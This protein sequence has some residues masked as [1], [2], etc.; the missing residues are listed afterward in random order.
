MSA[1]FKFDVQA[2][3]TH[4]LDKDLERFGHFRSRNALAL[5]DRLVGLDTTGGIVG[6][7]REDLLQD[8]GCAIRIERPNLHL[9]EALAAELGFTTE[10]LL[11]DKTVRTS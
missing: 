2:Q 11:R 7:D 9:A 10:R 3:R 5:D 4:F 6:V 1:A 8:V